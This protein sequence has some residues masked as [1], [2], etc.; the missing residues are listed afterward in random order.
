MPP[1]KQAKP[2]APR[3][4]YVEGKQRCGRAGTGNPPLCEPHRVVL[5]AEANRP[6]TAGSRIADLLSSVLRGKKV[7]DEQVV[8]GVEDFVDMFTRSAGDPAH[9]PIAAARARAADFIRRTQGQQQR[10][11]PPPPR[12][13]DPRIAI[14]KARQTLGFN[15]TDKLTEDMVKK[16]HRELARKHHPDRGGSVARMQEINAA[17]DQ[18][19]ATL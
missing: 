4:A 15:P 5:E 8:G 1:K 6:R 14:A 12:G 3:C 9:D 17:V 18:V 19:L 7:T 10:Q 2:R 16:R 13:P 11:A